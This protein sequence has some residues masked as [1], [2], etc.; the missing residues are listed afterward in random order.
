MARLHLTDVVVQRLKTPGIYYDET[1]PAFGVRVGKNRKTW[2]ITRGTDRQ[3]IAI[4]RYP[5]MSLAEARKEA[6]KRLVEEPAPRGGLTFAEA[7]EEYEAT[8]T[9]KKP[10]TQTEYKRLLGKYFI[11]RLGKKRLRE[12]TY[13]Q[14]VACV[15][16]AAPSEAAHA[17]VVCRAFLRWC[18]KPPR[19]YIPHSPLEGVEVKVAKKRKRILNPE[20]LR[21]VWTAAGK[22]SYP[23]GVIVRLLILTGQRR[24]EIANLRW[25][26]IDQQAQTITLPGGEDGVTKNKLEHTFPYN[27]MVAKI[28]ETIPRRNSTD[29]LFPSKVSDERP[30]SGWSKFKKELADGVPGW[31]LHDL[32]RTYRSTHGAIGTPREIAERLINHAAGVQTEVEAIYDRYSYLPQMREAVERY[33]AHLLGLMPA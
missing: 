29:L 16:D 28:L 19:R 11:P 1:T 31:T 5:I 32:R 10:K 2:V 3:R 9:T 18:V 8:L 4:G 6:K 27:G 7:Y 14:V 15:A 33:E 24:G 30:L 25:P 26:W 21:T 20:E 12:L 23:H 22:Q 13:E 17:L